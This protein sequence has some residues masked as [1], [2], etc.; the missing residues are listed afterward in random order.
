MKSALLLPARVAT[1]ASIGPATAPAPGSPGVAT[2]AH[3]AWFVVNVTWYVPVLRCDAAVTPTP[4]TSAPA[5]LTTAHCCVAAACA[6]PGDANTAAMTVASSN[7]RL[8]RPLLDELIFLPALLFPL[9]TAMRTQSVE[10]SG[11]R[12]ACLREVELAAIR[13]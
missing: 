6:T 10:T 11:P 4:R 13:A 9:D 7:H 3:A 1:V 5:E 12:A 8:R 2:Y